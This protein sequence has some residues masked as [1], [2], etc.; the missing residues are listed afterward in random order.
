[1]RTV[2]AIEKLIDFNTGERQIFSIYNSE[3]IA[4]TRLS[5]FDGIQL[6]ML[7]DGQIVPEYIVTERIVVQ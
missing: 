5:M 2:Y 7:A 1:M 4:K 6:V 3:D